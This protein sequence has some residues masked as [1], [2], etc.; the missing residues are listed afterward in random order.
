MKRIIGLSVV[1]A[2]LWALAPATVAHAQEGGGGKAP[3]A[4]TLSPR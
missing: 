3:L 4:G 1:L 2:L